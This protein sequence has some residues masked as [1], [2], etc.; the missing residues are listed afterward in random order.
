MKRFKVG[1]RVHIKSFEKL[2]GQ[3]GEMRGGFIEMPG[4]AGF[5]SSMSLFCG[6]AVIISKVMTYDDGEV[7]YYLREDNDE[8]FWT[9]Y[10]FEEGDEEKKTPPD[11]YI[12]YEENHGP[13]S[14]WTNIHAAYAEAK[15]LANEN[16]DD[17][18]EEITDDDIAEGTYGITIRDAT[19]NTPWVG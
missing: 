9:G 6:E 17:Y 1:D 10:M 4:T 18:Y 15:R 7:D 13:V 19:L 16:A 12:V 2:T 8:F 14:Y 3:Y 5:V 11:L